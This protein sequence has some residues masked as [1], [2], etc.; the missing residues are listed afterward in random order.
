MVQGRDSN[1][2]CVLGTVLICSVL[3]ALSVFHLTIPTQA[4]ETAQNLRSLFERLNEQIQANRGFEIVVKFKTP[5]VEGQDTWIIPD[6]RSADPNDEISIYI[7][8]IGDDYIC[9]DA[10]RGSARDIDCTPYSNIVLV[11]HLVD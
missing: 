8:E 7:S 4:Q 11:R 10:V 5:L 1:K 3:V 2:K 6:T 9:F